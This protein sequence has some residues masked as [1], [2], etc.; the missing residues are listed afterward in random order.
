M[1][2]RTYT[3]CSLRQN[4][5]LAIGRAMTMTASR[6]CGFSSK[7]QPTTSHRV[8]MTGQRYSFTRC[9]CNWISSASFLFLM[10]L[11][12]PGAGDLKPAHPSRDAQ[13]S[14]AVRGLRRA[15]ILHSAEWPPLHSVL[16]FTV[17]EG[18]Q[19]ADSAAYAQ[20]RIAS[21]GPTKRAKCPKRGRGRAGAETCRD[22]RQSS[23]TSV[24]L[25][26]TESQHSQSCF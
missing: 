25:L 22:S 18:F 13:E 14:R 1:L 2:M 12:A 19:R 11:P 20:S 7:G 5:L 23:K 3:S 26:R 8:R 4:A 6:Y 21:G 9:K 17:K 16:P 15:V 24:R 10:L